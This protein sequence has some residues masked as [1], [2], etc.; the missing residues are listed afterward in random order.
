M[1]S[2]E[3]GIAAASTTVF[4]PPFLHLTA[5]VPPSTAPL[6][7]QSQLNSNEEKRPELSVS[8]YID[9][10]LHFKRKCIL[11]RTLS[12]AGEFLGFKLFLYK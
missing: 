9:L 10:P 12:I 2:C 8:L 4:F 3:S 5:E 7:T 1:T 6:P 11:E